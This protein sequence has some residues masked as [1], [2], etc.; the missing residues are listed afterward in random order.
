MHQVN[1]YQARLA[2]LGQVWALAA[3]RA[4]DLLA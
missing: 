3:A 2:Y 1:S 4:H